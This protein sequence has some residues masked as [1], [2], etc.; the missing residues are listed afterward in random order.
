MPSA[1]SK[2]TRTVQKQ[3][4]LKISVQ[5]EGRGVHTGQPCRVVIS[6][7]ESNS[8]FCFRRQ[9][10]KIP[11][12]AKYITKTSG[13]MTLTHEKISI[14]TTEHLL[15]ALVGLG[16]HH[17]NIDVSGPELPILDGSSLPW[18]RLLRKAGIKES[19]LPVLTWKLNQTLVFRN[20][21]SFARLTPSEQTIISCHISLGQQ[22]QFAEFNL[23]KNLFETQIAPARTYV[24]QSIINQ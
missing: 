22:T 13:A 18:V 14:L 24:Q 2:I 9:G 8:G 7:S 21:H 20:Q 5:I 1:L 3:C 11:A 10:V 15:A 6:P 19:H 12:L 23:Q 4:T 17:A 16:Y